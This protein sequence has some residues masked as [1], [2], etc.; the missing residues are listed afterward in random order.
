[1][2]EKEGVEGIVSVLGDWCREKGGK[3]WC[4]KCIRGNLPPQHSNHRSNLT[5]SLLTQTRWYKG[6]PAAMK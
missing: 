6:I 5:A 4:W 3:N 1:M 2:W